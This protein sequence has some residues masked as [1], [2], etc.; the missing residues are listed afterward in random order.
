MNIP[1]QTS[2]QIGAVL[3]MVRKLQGVRSDDLAGTAGVGPVF[4]IDMEKGKP[5][6]QLGKVLQVLHE[7]GIQVN[8]EIPDAFADRPEGSSSAGLD[9]A[10]AIEGAAARSDSSDWTQTLKALLLNRHRAFNTPSH[11]TRSN[12]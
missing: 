12:D 3:R 7:A 9:L 2:A 6:V 4:V 5:T 11:K 10:S 8:L 1:V